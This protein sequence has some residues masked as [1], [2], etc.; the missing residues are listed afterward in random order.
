MRLTVLG[1]FLLLLAVNLI[2]AAVGVWRIQARRLVDGKTR[3]WHIGAAIFGALIAG[4]LM[5]GATVQTFLTRPE[6]LPAMSR[7]WQVALVIAAGIVGSAGAT[8]AVC[9]HLRLAS[10]RDPDYEPMDRPPDPG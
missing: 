7:H 1:F 4:M 10:R 2:P 3:G 8:T 6:Q 5:N 9:L